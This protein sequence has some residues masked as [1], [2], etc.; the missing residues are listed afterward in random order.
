MEPPAGEG[1]EPLRDERAKILRAI[2]PMSPERV[3][4]GQFTG[5]RNEAGVA[6]D[7]AVETYIAV[8][9]EIDSWRWQGVP[10]YIRAGKCL[11]VTATEVVVELK[12]PPMQVFDRVCVERPNYV[13]FRLG[14]DRIAIAIGAR[15]KK[16]GDAMQG[17]EIELF[18]ADVRPDETL[19]YERLI[20][21]ALKGDGTL[22]ARRDGIESAW[23]AVEPLL[24]DVKPVEFY[25]PGSW[26]PPSAD[27][28][29][30]KPGYWKNPV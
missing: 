24:R 13:R 10:F 23:R 22:F 15:A 11:P 26:G 21:D 1:M 20:G 27:G 6:S 14:P 30:P 25:E 2:K 3:V 9:L 4:R 28:F 29:V 7:S 19:A 16:H 8:Q 5:Y 17:E 18:V 12:A